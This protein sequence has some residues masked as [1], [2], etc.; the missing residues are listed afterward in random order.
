MFFHTLLT[1]ECDLKCQYCY[2][3]A[4]ADIDSDFPFAIDYSLPRTI[5]YD[6]VTL[7]RFCAQDPQCGIGFY[8][9]EPT[10]CWD[11]MKQIMDLTPVKTLV[12][13]TNGLHLDK[14][15][16]EYADRLNP[17][18][19]SIDG[20]PALTNHYRGAG[21]SRRVIRNLRALRANGFTGEIIARMT[22]GEATD[23]AE[24]VKWLLANE[25]F[26]FA[27]VHWQLD[28]G[29]WKNDFPRRQF[30]T[31]VRDSYDPGIRQLIRGWVDTMEQRGEMLRLYPFLG[32]T[33]SLLSKEKSR[34]RCGSGWSSYSILTDGSIVPCPA[35]SGMKDFYL[36]HISDANPLSLRKVFV[37]QP[38]TRC[39]I[40]A[41]CGGRCLYANLTRRWEAD[42]YALVCGTVRN[43]VGALKKETPRIRRL[44]K[45]GKIAQ[46]DLESAE[47]CGC[48]VIP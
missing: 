9:G 34:L 12:L 15:T 7:T 25:E 39:A 22:V 18:F 6:P 48:E 43:L 29:F 16:P 42:A 36:G 37:S 46:S 2:E 11:E 35:M 38:C 45:R 10:L 5:N 8:G 27:S 21:V 32:V 47:F 14:L 44:L 28:A 26:S 3:K 24:E 31:W 41:E 23:I 4:C 33:R 17:I 30:A 20:R 1:T 40:F 19:V 13:Q